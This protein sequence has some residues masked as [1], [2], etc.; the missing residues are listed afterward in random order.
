MVMGGEGTHAQLVESD[1]KG[2]SVDKQ[3]KTESNDDWLIDN[4]LPSE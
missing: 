2:I 3:A 4:N 1:G